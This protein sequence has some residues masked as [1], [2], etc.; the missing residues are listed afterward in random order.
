MSDKMAA[1][2]T[3]LSGGT[4]FETPMWESLRLMREEGF[5][6]ADIVFITDGECE[7]PEHFL[8]E[9]R[10]EQA[11]R[12]FTIVGV[13]LDSG[14]H[15]MEFSLRSFCQNIYRTSELAGE[16]IVRELVGKRV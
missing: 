10:Q 9:L 15:G 4:N 2:E 11:E 12:R 16:E 13:L 1:A 5:E 14:S 8:T 7:M 3:S 6:N